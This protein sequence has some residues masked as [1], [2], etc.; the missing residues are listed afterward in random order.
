MTGK[1]VATLIS[2]ALLWPQLCLAQS[3][4]DIRQAL[5]QV[6]CASESLAGASVLTL[7]TSI[8]CYQKSR[9]DWIP[10]GRLSDD[11]VATLLTDAAQGF[12][13]ENGVRS[14][15]EVASEVARAAAEAAAEV[16]RLNDAGLPEGPIA[17][18]DP[19]VQHIGFAIN[20][21]LAVTAVIE[22]SPAY[23]AGVRVGDVFGRGAGGEAFPS[24]VS[25]TKIY[26]GIS[27]KL[28]QRVESNATT[29]VRFLRDGRAHEAPFPPRALGAVLATRSLSEDEKNVFDLLPRDLSGF[30]SAIYLDEF[31]LAQTFQAVAYDRAFAASPYGTVVTAFGGAETARERFMKSRGLGLIAQFILI[32]SNHLGACDQPMTDITVTQERYRVLVDGY[33]SEIG[34]RRRIEPNVYAFSVPERWAAH[35]LNAEPMGEYPWWNADIRAFVTDAGGCDSSILQRLEAGMLRYLAT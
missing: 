22:N 29:S 17:L 30:F 6:G 34:P 24:G 7:R 4:T 10:S 26:E 32:K 5:M 9:A 19:L 11:Q 28:Q 18:N 16:R 31:E 3:D 2:A 8:R 20:D 15:A 25:R 13:V 14:A 35:L 12:K 33:G 27:R 23:F 1:A 21:D